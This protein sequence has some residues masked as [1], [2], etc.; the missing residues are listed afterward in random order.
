MTARRLFQFELNLTEMSKRKEKRTGNTKDLEAQAPPKAITQLQ[1]NYVQKKKRADGAMQG[2]H[3][4][5]PVV[6]LMKQEAVR[7]HCYLRPYLYLFVH[8][9]LLSTGSVIDNVFELI[10]DD[11]DEICTSVRYD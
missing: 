6:R 10:E 11:E 9:L 1:S 4:K 3:S 8:T 5:K 2:K 7:L